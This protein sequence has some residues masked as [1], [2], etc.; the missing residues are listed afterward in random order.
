MKYNVLLD[1]C[2]EILVRKVYKRAP[3]LAP[4]T[5]TDSLLQLEAHTIV[6]QLIGALIA[7]LEPR[8]SSPA[9]YAEKRRIPLAK[10]HAA[11][12]PPGDVETHELQPWRRRA[13]RTMRLLYRG[14]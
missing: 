14:H 4:Y 13:A 2:G 5:S 10:E 8:R 6:D 9:K 7:L 1:V 3:I 11:T 12:V